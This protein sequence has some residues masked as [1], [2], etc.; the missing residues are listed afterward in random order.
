MNVLN[1]CRVCLEEAITI[2][3]L[4]EFVGNS[5]VTSMILK[6]CPTANVRFYEFLK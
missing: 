3:N 2:Y 4:H 1:C 5:T 6:I